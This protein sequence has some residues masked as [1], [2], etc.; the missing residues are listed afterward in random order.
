MNQVKR[1]YE[2]VDL[3]DNVELTFEVDADELIVNDVDISRSGIGFQTNR[4]LSIQVKIHYEN[5]K[6]V[7]K[8]AHL[9]WTNRNEDGTMKYG[10]E[11]VGPL[12]TD[13]VIGI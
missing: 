8:P 13:D 7:E 3:P 5:G 6:V 11:F 10:F 12:D 1:Q 9:V 2:R 4:P